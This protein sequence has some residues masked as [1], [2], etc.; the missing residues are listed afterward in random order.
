MEAIIKELEA[1]RGSAIFGS[2]IFVLFCAGALILMAARRLGLG[3]V[4]LGAGCLYYL[5]LVRR[6]VK[7]FTGLFLE[8]NL[9]AGLGKSLAG[10]AYRD[11]AGI[12]R[13]EIF[14]AGLLPMV[15]DS[16]CITFHRVTGSAKGLTAELCDVT[17]QPVRE[18]RER[19]RFVSG[20]WIAMTLEQ[21]TG[22]RLRMVSRRLVAE[23]AAERWYPEAGFRPFRWG[24]ERVD[25]EFYSCGEA[26]LGDSALG[27]LMDLVE[28]TPGTVAMGVEGN[29]LWFF[30]GR[31]LLAGGEPGL[32]EAVTE[33][34]LRRDPLPELEYL[35]KTATAIRRGCQGQQEAE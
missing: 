14:R 18:E 11:Y 17:F 4:L 6:D 19:L 26:C 15:E 5:L 22:C 32:K 34:M 28:F 2:V 3:L 27:R 16:S 9:E 29:R 20:C 12:P 7:K 24:K 8:K 31:R 10:A 25:G 30:L 21:D 33:A 1:K 23:Q 35:L 13:E